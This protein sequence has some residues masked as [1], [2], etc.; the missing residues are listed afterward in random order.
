MDRHPSRWPL[1][2]FFSPVE[3]NST[4]MS[5]LA[6]TTGI[7]PKS[8][9][10]LSSRLAKLQERDQE[11]HEHEQAHFRAAGEL[12]LS[13]P[14]ITDYVDG[15]DGRRYADGGHVMID[16][17]QTGDPREDLR[18]GQ[19]I[20][21]A[22]EAPEEVHSDLSDAD[23]KVAAAGRAMIAK[24]TPFV[25]KLNDLKSKL[26]GRAHEMPRQV[27]TTLATG[28]GL[29]LPAGRLVSLLG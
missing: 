5:S 13:G 28:L 24:N 4:S 17:S 2:G 20:L 3:D 15:P 11:V 1:Q 18:R 22:A 7:A 27:L 12:A 23:R 9:A 16:T 6:P 29:E 14:V 8:L 10:G 19:I 25:E 26:G 21:R